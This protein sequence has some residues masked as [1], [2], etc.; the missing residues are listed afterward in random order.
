MSNDVYIL[1]VD[2]DADE[3]IALVKD[4][5]GAVQAPKQIE[6]VEAIPLTP[7]GKPDKKAIRARYWGSEDRQ[8]H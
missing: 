6:F 8:V 1:G 3:L 2:I 5:K 7:L 4:K